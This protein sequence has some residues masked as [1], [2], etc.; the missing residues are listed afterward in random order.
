MTKQE[1]LQMGQR[2]RDR[3][4]KLNYTLDT[5]AEMTGISK[6]TLHR[7]ETGAISSANWDKLNAIADAL[8]TTP[9]YL[10]GSQSESEMLIAAIAG[11][12]NGMSKEELNVYF[13]LLEGAKDLNLTAPDVDFLLG[14]ARK[15]KGNGPQQ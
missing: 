9:Q 8:A 13:H 15:I 10:T 6:A 4:T 12:T 3:R 14:I 2:I 1:I 7:Y 11:Q 5:L